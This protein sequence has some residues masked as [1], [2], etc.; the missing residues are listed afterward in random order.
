MPTTEED[1]RLADKKVRPLRSIVSGKVI[2]G[3]VYPGP[4]S[5][6]EYNEVTNPDG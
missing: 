6:Q 1:I 3:K 2:E 5:F 4:M